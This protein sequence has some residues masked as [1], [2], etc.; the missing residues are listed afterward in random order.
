MNWPMVAPAGWWWFLQQHAEGDGRVC[1]C[2]VE[3]L[4]AEPA[5]RRE[6]SSFGL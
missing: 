5:A 6:S 4:E 3:G 2:L 1:R